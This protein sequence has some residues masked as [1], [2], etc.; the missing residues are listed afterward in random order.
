MRV[1]F[2]G[3]FGERFG[4]AH[5]VETEPGDTPITIAERMF[6]A[7]ADAL[8][9]LCHRSTSYIVDHAVVPSDHVLDKAE[10]L[11]FLPPVSGG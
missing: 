8:E 1:L 4:P 10:E 5:E 6:D 7:D 9:A 11:A 3:K 2:F